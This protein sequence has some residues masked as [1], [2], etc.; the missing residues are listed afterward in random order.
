MLEIEIVDS[1]I[2]E[3]GIEVFA[4][5]WNE[6]GQ[7]GFGKDGTVDIERFRIFN[8][9]ILVEDPNGEIN[10]DWVEERTGETI[11][12]RLTE[13][14]EEALLQT[15]EHNIKQVGKSG[16]SIIPGKIGNTTSTFYPDANT[17]NTSV[18]GRVGHNP[19]GATPYSW[20]TFRDGAGTYSAD[21]SASQN[22]FT[23][24]ASTSTDL[25]DNF[26]R[27]IWLFD[28]SAISD[29]VDSAILSVYPSLSYTDGFTTPI[30]AAIVESAPASNT[31]L[32]AGDYDSFTYTDLATRQPVTNLTSG[33]YVDFA[34]NSTGITR[35]QSFVDGDGIVKLGMMTGAEVD[36]VNPW[37]SGKEIYGTFYFADQ[38][39][40]TN[41]PKLVVVHSAAAT[42]SIK[43]VNGILRANIKSWNGVILE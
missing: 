2:I 27:T 37:E 7:I 22:S 26:S 5:A 15:L 35:M 30:D 28:A 38:A 18:D 40:T 13:N 1:N 39:G 43:S 34:L 11:P 17:E 32:V 9:P 29:N 16:G 36:D 25:W 24:D 31:A 19:A 20:A 42:S 10:R 41:D 14:P 23:I 4:R 6:N 21:D 3:G 33:G 8:P 12:H